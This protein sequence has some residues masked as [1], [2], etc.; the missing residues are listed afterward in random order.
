MYLFHI[1]T[2]HGHL[3]LKNKI[4]S[5]H[6]RVSKYQVLLT[7]NMYHIVNLEAMRVLRR[8]STYASSVLFLNFQLCTCAC[9]TV[10]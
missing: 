6:T 5:T 4:R 10:C 1:L 3:T 8:V 7:Q 2:R 9:L